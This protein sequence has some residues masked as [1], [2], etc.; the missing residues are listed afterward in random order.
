MLKTYRIIYL[1]LHSSDFD[2][3]DD[4]ISIGNPMT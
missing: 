2:S 1:P 3:V 4:I